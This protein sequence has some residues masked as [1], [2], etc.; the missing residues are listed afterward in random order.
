VEQFYY[1]IAGA[2]E[3][4]AFTYESQLLDTNFEALLHSYREKDRILQRT[5]AGIHKDDIDIRYGA[6]PF[7]S[8]AS[9]GQRKSLLFALKLAEYE[10]LKQYKGFPP[11]LLLD[12]VFEKLDA[13]RMHN[14]LDKVCLQNEGQIFITDTHGERIRHELEKLNIPSQIIS[15]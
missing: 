1:Q 5:N 14:L 7:K 6:L 9:Q 8:I 12:D 13:H 4:L 10:M 3:P 11:L 15:L 2:P